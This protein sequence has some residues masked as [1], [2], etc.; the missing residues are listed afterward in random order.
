MRRGSPPSRREDRR[1]KAGGSQTGGRLRRA[2]SAGSRMFHTVEPGTT[3]TGLT[4]ASGIGGTPEVSARVVVRLATL[5][6]DGP[7]GTFQ[8]EN[9]E[10][11]W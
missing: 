5:D 6:A 11:P 1:K 2:A 10:V 8:Y 4:A 9:G 7:T 3:A